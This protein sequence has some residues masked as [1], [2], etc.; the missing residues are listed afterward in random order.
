MKAGDR[1]NMPED[2]ARALAALFVQQAASFDSAGKSLAKSK[3]SVDMPITGGS[4][5]AALPKGT[6]IRVSLVDGAVCNAGDVVVFRQNEQIVAHRVIHR[7]PHYLITRGDSRIAPD[8]PV[9][10]L[11]VLGR[12]NAV[13]SS[14]QLL[15]VPGMRRRRWI[16]RAAN[17]V[18]GGISVV[19]LRISPA[20]AAVASR[21]LTWIERRS[22]RLL[23]T[24]PQ[25]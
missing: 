4:M 25:H 17:A 9:P 7:A 2:A 10:F 13:L 19:A 1:P 22:A 24:R 12:V 20:L 23:R 16:T 6:I 14:D 15:A 8:P 11:R 5:G 21:M 3:Q 18:A